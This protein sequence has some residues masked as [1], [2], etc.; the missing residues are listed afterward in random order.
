MCLS[1]SQGQDASLIIPPS[2][3]QP[4]TLEKCYSL[5]FQFHRVRR[6]R[7]NKAWRREGA[8]WWGG[9]LRPLFGRQVILS[10]RSCP[11]WPGPF[12]VTLWSLTNL[13]ET[14]SIRTSLEERKEAQAFF[15]NFTPYR[16]VWLMQ[17]PRT[18]TSSLLAH[19]PHPMSGHHHSDKS[20]VEC[21]FFS[22]V[23]D[24][25]R[26]AFTCL[27]LSPLPAGRTLLRRSF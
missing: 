1:S 19:S 4:P 25:S 24:G 14:G 21:F 6:Q 27:P 13:S 16:P 9:Y 20:T 12:G 23:T 15:F 26:D 8:L 5:E 11:I 7:E 22:Q 17:A 3:P 18:T 10:I 2:P